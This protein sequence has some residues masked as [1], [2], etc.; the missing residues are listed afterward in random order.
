L[1]SSLV[2]TSLIPQ[3]SVNPNE[4]H[5]ERVRGDLVRPIGARD[6]ELL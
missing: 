2:P 5:V 4:G 1:N 6:G 3:N